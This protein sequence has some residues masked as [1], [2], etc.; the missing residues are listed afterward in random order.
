MEKKKKKKKTKAERLEEA[1]K[2]AATAFAAPNGSYTAEMKDGKLSVSSSL[3]YQGIKFTAWLTG[4]GDGSNDSGSPASAMHF[5]GKVSAID[6]TTDR[7]M[8]SFG[9]AHSLIQRVINAT[10]TNSEEMIQAKIYLSVE[11]LYH[12][13]SA[14]CEDAKKR[15]AALNPSVPDAEE[16]KQKKKHKAKPETRINRL[17]ERD[18][19]SRDELDFA[20]QLLTENAGDTE[21]LIALALWG[22]I[23]YPYSAKLTAD[24]FLQIS[25][26]VI[27]VQMK[28]TDL[29][30]ERT[31]ATHN[32]TTPL[33]PQAVEVIDAYMRQHNPGNVID[34]A[35][36]AFPNPSLI[37]VSR[38][39]YKKAVKAFLNTVKQQF[40]ENEKVACLG[41]GTRVLSETY[42][43]TVDKHCGISVENTSTSHYLMHKSLAGSVTDDHYASYIGEDAWRQQ[44]AYLK[45]QAP[46]RPIPTPAA[47]PE[48]NGIYYEK[49]T[50]TTTG[51]TVRIQLEIQ[52]N[53]GETLA[54][55]SDSR[56]EG[57]VEVISQ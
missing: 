49:I 36:R 47:I 23:R 45:R 4:S 52:L 41:V 22:D 29:G 26:E 43:Y 55:D 44:Y 18:V 50:P 11:D 57:W 31:G 7:I 54:V 42:R 56:V 15:F 17:K 3:L 24:S 35:K 27:C 37:P 6:P 51:K 39:K 40:P 10:L 9:E 38:R 53:P 8:R 46:E 28:D 5:R 34:P 14:V 1:K 25:P 16:K 30:K 32:M 33:M 48:E 20:L 12:R 21:L 13:Y 2:H 19:M